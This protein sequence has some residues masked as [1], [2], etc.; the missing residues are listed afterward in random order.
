MIGCKHFTIS[1]KRQRCITTNVD[2]TMALAKKLAHHQSVHSQSWGGTPPPEPDF[3][4]IKSV[5]VEI[6]LCGQN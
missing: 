1:T 2:L 4:T 5:I 3:I 6:C